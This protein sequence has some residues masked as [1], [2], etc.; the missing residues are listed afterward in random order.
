MQRFH[1]INRHGLRFTMLAETRKQACNA[2]MRM[3]GR[4]SLPHY[5]SVELYS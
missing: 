4:R 5:I 3:L 1:V 2:V